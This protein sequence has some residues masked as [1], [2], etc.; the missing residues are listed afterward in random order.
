MT[1]V[2]IS[3]E[4]KS[5]LPRVL[6]VSLN[7]ASISYSIVLNATDGSTILQGQNQVTQV[8]PVSTAPLPEGAVADPNAAAKATL[9]SAIEAAFVTY[10]EATNK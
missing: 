10:Y 9:E 5:G 7:N 6:K 1:Q 2:S 8:L 4:P 3:N